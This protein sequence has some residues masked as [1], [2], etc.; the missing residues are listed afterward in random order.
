MSDFLTLLKDQTRWNDIAQ[1]RDDGYR[2]LCN[3]AECSLSCANLRDGVLSLTSIHGKERHS[4]KLTK[5]DMAFASIMFLDSLTKED[6]EDF[7]KMFNK[8]SSKYNIIPENMLKE[9]M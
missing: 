3:H 8:V 2:L 6:L 9:K 7:A 1:S 5:Y 4:Y